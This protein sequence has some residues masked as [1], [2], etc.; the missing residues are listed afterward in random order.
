MIKLIFIPIIFSLLLN[1]VISLQMLN[2]LTQ[3][4]N[5]KKVSLALSI[6]IG[7]IMGLLIFIHP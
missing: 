2:R 3:E 5:T 1:W 6:A 7:V 4:K